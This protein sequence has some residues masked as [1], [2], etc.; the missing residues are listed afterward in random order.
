MCF[1]YNCIIHTGVAFLNRSVVESLLS[2]L[3][4]PGSILGHVYFLFADSCLLQLQHLSSTVPAAHITCSIGRVAFHFFSIG[5]AVVLCTLGS[6]RNLTS[7]H[8]GPV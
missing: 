5:Q 6:G 1:K 8:L 4:V 2:V 7:G 3:E